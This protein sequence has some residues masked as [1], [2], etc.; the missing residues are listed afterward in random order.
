MKATQQ[1][2]S[3]LAWPVY[4]TEG[5]WIYFYG[6]RDGGW[7]PGKVARFHLYRIKPYYGATPEKL[8][9]VDLLAVPIY[10]KSENEVLLVRRDL[11]STK[12]SV[13]ILSLDPN[14]KKIKSLSRLGE[15][16]RSATFSPFGDSL[17]FTTNRGLFSRSVTGGNITVNIPWR[18][19]NFP[20]VSPDGNRMLTLTENGVSI[21]IN[22]NTGEAE[23][24]GTM[25]MPLGA[26][27]KDGKLLLTRLENGK[28]KVISIDLRKPLTPSENFKNALN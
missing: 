8:T 23:F 19:F 10:F 15:P 6:A 26:F 1:F 17:L 28:H 16:V 13:E 27:G 2:L 24:I 18:K 5:K 22:R 25:G 12:A 4:S 9:N 21:L 11:G 14:R 20:L 3:S 7:S